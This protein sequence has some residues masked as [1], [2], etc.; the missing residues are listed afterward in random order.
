[1]TDDRPEGVTPAGP[2]ERAARVA[3]CIATYRR[4]R[5]LSELLASLGGLAFPTDPPELA[6]I[7]VDN[8]AE[9]TAEPIVDVARSGL[10]G[11]VVYVREAERNISAARNAGVRAALDWGA[12]FLAFVDD[13]EVVTPTWLA[14]LLDVQSRY[15]ADAVCGPAAPRFE[16]APPDWVTRGGFFLPHHFRTGSR[17]DF[18]VTNN[19]LLAAKLVSADAEPFDRDFGISGGGDAHF[20]LRAAHRG[21]IIVWAE[22]AL[23]EETIPS[24]RVRA[25]WILRRAFRIGHAYVRCRR[26][27]LPRWRW[28]PTTIAGAA[29]RIALG[30]I[31]MLPLTLLRGRAGL[32]SAAR[33]VMHGFGTMAALGGRSYHE[34]TRVHG[35]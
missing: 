13:D 24:S 4:P 14:E 8:D 17:L 18:G 20:F 11:S 23:V 12:D 10:P 26:A 6:I 25:D 34:Y 5:M 7:V 3:I 28:M 33:T 22:E 30:G 15:A 16:T 32:V 31:S 1:M 2:G 19:A 29:A 21:A 9:G 35:G 27:V